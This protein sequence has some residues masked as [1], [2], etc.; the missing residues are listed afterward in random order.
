MS[1]G[2][3]LV[4]GELARPSYVQAAVSAWLVAGGCGESAA[5]RRQHHVTTSS[6]HFPHT[7]EQLHAHWRTAVSCQPI[8]S[9]LAGAGG[10]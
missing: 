10:R 8:S 4:Y 9:E 6:P 2:S 1:E 3:P 7:G 5:G